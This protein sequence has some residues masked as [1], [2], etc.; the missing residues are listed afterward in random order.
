MSEWIDFVCAAWAS[1]GAQ[2]VSAICLAV[3]PVCII[4]NVL[5]IIYLMAQVEKKRATMRHSSPAKSSR[6]GSDGE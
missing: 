6:R 1:G 5:H 4:I 2:R 3:L